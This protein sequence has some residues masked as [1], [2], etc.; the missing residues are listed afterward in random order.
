[1]APKTRPV[2]DETAK[3]LLVHTH[4]I[5]ATEWDDDP[6]LSWFRTGAPHPELNAVIRASPDAIE[7]SIDLMAGVPALWT[8]WA[9]ESDAAATERACL[10]NGLRFVEEEPVMVRDL[11]GDVPEPSPVAG[12]EVRPVTTL[13]ELTRWVDFW[14]ADDSSAAERAAIVRALAPHSLEQVGDPDSV[15][16]RHLLA[17]AAGGADAGRV[18]GCAAA[19]IV[20]PSAAVEHLLTAADQRGRGIGSLLTAS[21]LGIARAAGAERA[22]LTASAAGRSLYERLGFVSRGRVRRYGWADGA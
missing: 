9:D 10:R 7:R 4:L 22:V 11:T 17:L 3:R 5:R 21:A 14:A 8:I 20:G 18:L 2:A 6:A 16:V 1:M 13:A 19:V 12:V 15:P